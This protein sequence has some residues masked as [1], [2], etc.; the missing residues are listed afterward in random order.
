MPEPILD[1]IA[2]WHK[3]RRV[4][5]PRRTPKEMR[6]VLIDQRSRVARRLRAIENDLRAQLRVQGRIVLVHDDILIGNLAQCMLRM[7]IMRGEQSRGHFV[8]DEQLT[9]LAN[10]SQ[11]WPSLREYLT[12]KAAE[13]SRGPSA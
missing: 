12:N 9:R 5:K 3:P 2:P 4:N 7:E 6:R 13:V 11:R 1:P 10:A 8:D